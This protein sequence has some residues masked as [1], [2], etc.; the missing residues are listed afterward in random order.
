MEQPNQSKTDCNIQSISADI[1]DERGN[2]HSRQI[3]E[4]QNSIN[5][6]NHQRFTTSNNNSQPRLKTIDSWKI[7][8]CC[9]LIGCCYKY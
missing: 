5:L 2:E 1:A 7:D 3:D 9:W 8:C 4:D 6:K